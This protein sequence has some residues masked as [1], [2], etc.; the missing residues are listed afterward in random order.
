MRI[1]KRL[2]TLMA[3]LALT[4]ALV[5]GFAALTSSLQI[6]IGHDHSATVGLS[7]AKDTLGYTINKTFSN[8]SGTAQVADLVYHGRRTLT[9]GQSE[10]LD[11]YGGLTDALGNTLNFARVKAIVIEQTSAS[12]TLTIGDAAAPLPLFG[13]ATATV[14]VK[15]SGAVALVAPLAGWTV[16]DGSTDGVKV[17][18][19]AGDSSIYN[20][21]IVGGGN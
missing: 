15:P 11:L 16:A 8:G 18:N 12:M 4:I 6:T 19:S 7:T 2:V 17:T 5:P 13:P 10:T 21:W 20:I 1:S 3:I 14:S 9:T